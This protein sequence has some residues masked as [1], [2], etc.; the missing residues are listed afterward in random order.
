MF[1]VGGKNHMGFSGSIEKPYLIHPA[2][3]PKYTLTVLGKTT[4]S[5]VEIKIVT[6][7]D[8]YFRN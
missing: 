7:M 4:T 3:W 8:D 5:M 1:G 6:K 2:S